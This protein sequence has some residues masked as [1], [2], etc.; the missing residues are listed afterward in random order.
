MV[1]FNKV[2]VMGNLTRDPELRQTKAGNNVGRAGLAV[3]ERV[4][5][6]EGYKDSVSFFDVVLFGGPAESLVKW[7]TKGS[8]ILIEGKLRQ[9]TWQGEGGQNRSKVVIIADRWH[10]AEGKKEA[11]SLGQESPQAAPTNA[12]S[13]ASTMDDVPF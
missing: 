3:N 7:F 9:E 4:K 5:T 6:Q 1:S 11:A 13:F 8:R 10:F 12:D 2:I